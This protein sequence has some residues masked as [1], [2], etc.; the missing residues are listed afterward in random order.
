MVL[1]KLG[2]SLRESLRKIA[3]AG[4]VDKETLETT[5]RDIQRSLLGADVNVKLVS[6]ISDNIKKRAADEKPKAGLSKRE[7]IVNIVYEE[8]TSALAGESEGLALNEKGQ[9][10]IMLV[11]LFGSGKTTTTAKLGK[12]QTKKGLKVSLIGTDIWRPAALEQLKQLGEEAN[13]K[14]YGGGK[15]PVKTIKDGMKQAAD[16]DVVIVDSAGRDALDEELTKELKKINKELKPD[17]TLLVLPAD[18]GQKA[19]DVATGFNDMVGIDGVILT[20]L[21]SSAKGGG[22]LSACAT[23]GVPIKFVGL[24]ERVSDFEEFN[25]TKFVSKLLGMGDLETL[26]KKTQEIFDGASRDQ[27]EAMMKGRLTLKDLYAQ[28]QGM[29]KMGPLKKV[30]EMLPMGVDLPKEQMDMSQERMNQFIFIMDS[31]TPEELENPDLLSGPR[32][33][34]IANGSG[35]RV[36][37]VRALLKQYNMTKKLIKRFGKNKRSMNKLMRQMGSGKMQA[38]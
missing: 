26:V 29:K 6:Q 20:K 14:V 35:R 11:G 12:Y 17:E 30:L 23:I 22:A 10:K 9:T 27:M 36:E 2:S 19:A 7:H 33:Q 32:V 18:L 37:D 1:D 31:M 8:L 24:G 4:Y 16:S 15:D 25:P 28:I 13:L 38:V 21:E 3:R 34:R 5:V